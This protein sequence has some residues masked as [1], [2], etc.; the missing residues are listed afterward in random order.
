M[1][2]DQKMDH[3]LG[4]AQDL[5]HQLEHLNDEE[6]S[7]ELS[8]FRFMACALMAQGWELEELTDHLNQE[9]EWCQE[10]E[11]DYRMSLN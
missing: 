2:F 10:F 8:L 11:A 9:W 6:F 3:M 5:K 7:F 4:V 1:N